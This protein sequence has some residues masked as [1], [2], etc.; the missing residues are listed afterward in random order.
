MLRG[1]ETQARSF[2]DSEI[3]EL[4]QS[5]SIV[6]RALDLCTANPILSL[7]SYMALL[8]PTI[9]DP[10]VPSQELVLSTTGCGD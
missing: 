5:D 10:Q 6:A 2:R 3:T 4:G 7:V 9:R 1:P 8:S